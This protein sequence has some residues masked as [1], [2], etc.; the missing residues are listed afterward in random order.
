MIGAADYEGDDLVEL[1]AV[2]AVGDEHPIDVGFD[3]KEELV[4]DVGGLGELGED[5]LGE[6][7]VEGGEGVG[8]GEGVG[9]GL[10]LNTEAD[11][12]V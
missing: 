7:L 12:V 3:G 2:R 8:E 6:V 5:G 9:G 10:G 11:E 1:V 4:E